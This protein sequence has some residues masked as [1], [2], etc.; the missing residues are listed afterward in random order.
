MFFLSICYYLY[1]YC[2]RIKA[3]A[4]EN[5]FDCKLSNARQIPSKTSHSMNTFHFLICYTPNY[6]SNFFLCIDFANFFRFLFSPDEEEGGSIIVEPENI[7]QDIEDEAE[8]EMEK[9]KKVK[10]KK[11]T[12]DIE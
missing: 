11:K 5:Y 12:S 2:N 4:F 1:L 7:I 9:A 8:I 10:K 6:S 3:A